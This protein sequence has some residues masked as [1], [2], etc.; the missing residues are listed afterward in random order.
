MVD[1]MVGSRRLLTYRRLPGEEVTNDQP[2]RT[3]RREEGATANDLNSFRKRV[4]FSVVSV[5][6]VRLS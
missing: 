1:C 2:S 3:R 5:L 4:R 6:E